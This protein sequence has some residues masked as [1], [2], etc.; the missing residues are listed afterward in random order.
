MEGVRG[1]LNKSW[2]DLFT[3]DG[4]GRREL[5]A[6]PLAAQA[7]PVPLLGFDNSVLTG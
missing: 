4:P 7:H 5:E 6:R 2:A 3:L 1:R